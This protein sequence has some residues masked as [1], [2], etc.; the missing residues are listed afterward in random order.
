MKFITLNDVIKLQVFKKKK[1]KKKKKT[2]DNN[3]GEVRDLNH[4]PSRGFKI[5]ITD[6]HVKV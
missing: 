3:L 2:I 4:V 6:L 1:K 5:S